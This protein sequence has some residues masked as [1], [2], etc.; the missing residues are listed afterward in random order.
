MPLH[1]HAIGTA[2]PRHSVDQAE[3][4]AIARNFIPLQP[5]NRSQVLAALFRRTR[6]RSRHSVV[7]ET[8]RGEE[9]RQ[10]FYLP[11][12]DASD[13]GP[14]TH[15]RMRLYGESAPRLAVEAARQALDASSVA[16]RDICHVITVTCTGFDSPGIDVALLKQLELDPGVSRTQV[17]FMGCHGALN[18]LRVAR[19]YAE[20]EPEAGILVCAIELC[21]LHYQYGWDSQKLVSNALFAD[22]AAAVVAGGVPRDETSDAWRLAASGS[23]LMPDTEDAMT[24][25]IG[26][27]GFEMTLSAEVPEH[28]GA[29]LRPWLTAWL[30]EQGLRLSD[31]GSWAIHPGGP[32]IVEAVAEALD[33]SADDI[34]PS[35]EV[36]AETGNMSSPTLLFILQQLQRR[37][38]RR[39]CVA[40]GFGPGLAVEAALLR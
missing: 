29:H 15:A 33:L 26:D 2:T 14:T 35:L 32:R 6:V 31:V 22:G 40:L 13:R 23:Q 10:S 38:A 34:G 8:P 30:G 25:R 4:A 18:A 3:A 12:I 28:I 7:L 39:P 17:G 9:P 5:P 37:A 1:L 16:P 36:F 20:A 24:W 19:G 27:H 21:S 11:A